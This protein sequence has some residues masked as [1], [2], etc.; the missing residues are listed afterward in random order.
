MRRRRMDIA[1][2]SVTKTFIGV[3][4]PFAVTWLAPGDAC[5]RGRRRS[6][7]AHSHLLPMQRKPDLAP[8]SQFFESS[9]CDRGANAAT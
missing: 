1:V 4:Q 6:P 8:D 5:R 3:I 7:G 2:A 9:V